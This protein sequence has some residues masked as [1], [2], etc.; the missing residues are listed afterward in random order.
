MIS[1]GRRDGKRSRIRRSSL[2]VGLAGWA[3]LDAAVSPAV[4]IVFDT[5]REINAGSIEQYDRPEWM[6]PSC[7]A[8]WDAMHASGPCCHAICCLFALPVHVPANLV[9]T[10]RRPYPDWSCE[11]WLNG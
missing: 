11:A 6:W 4:S 10:V 3:G 1:G 2:A 9:L 5:G 8:Q 7:V